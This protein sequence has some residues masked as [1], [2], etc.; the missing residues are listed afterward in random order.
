MSA[1]GSLR[2]NRASDSTEGF[3]DEIDAGFEANSMED[4]CPWKWAA[5]LK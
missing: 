2:P 3:L 5:V 1:W 4:S